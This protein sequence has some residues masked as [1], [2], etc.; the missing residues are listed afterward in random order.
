MSMLS[1]FYTCIFVFYRLRGLRAGIMSYD[2]PSFGGAPSSPTGGAADAE[3][4]QFIALETQKA[5]FQ[6]TIHDITDQCWEKCMDKPRDKLDYK[7]EGC[8]SNCVDRFVDT[9]LII[10]QRFQQMLQK[11]A[12]Q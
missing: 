7:T 3:L 5:Q 9:T 12:G 8:M 10:T 1:H 11:H 2:L 4:Q 6:K